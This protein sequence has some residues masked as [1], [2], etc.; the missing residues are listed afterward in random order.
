MKNKYEL[1]DD[2]W[3]NGPGTTEKKQT[4]FQDSKIIT[5]IAGLFRKKIQKISN[6]QEEIE[7]IDYDGS[8][9]EVNQDSKAGQSEK[10][11]LG[12]ITQHPV[13]LMVQ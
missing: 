11:T 6:N 1:L 13:Q 7:M 10:F 9:T 4:R 2:I 12:N 8:D 3:M 5:V